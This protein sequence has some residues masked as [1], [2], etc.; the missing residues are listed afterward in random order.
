MTNSLVKCDLLLAQFACVLFLLLALFPIMG[1]AEIPA[2]EEELKSSMGLGGYTFVYQLPDGTEITF[3][4]LVEL[5]KS[6]DYPGFGTELPDGQ[7]TLTLTLL[8]AAE[9]AARDALEELAVATGEEMPALNLPD[10][11]GTV[12]NYEDFG[13]KPLLISFYFSLCPP[14]IKEIPELNEFARENPQVAVVAITFDSTDEARLFAAK[15]GYDWR[16]IADAQGFIDQVGVSAYPAMALVSA[17]GILIATR[18]GEFTTNPD[19]PKVE[20]GWL[21]AWVDEALLTA[22]R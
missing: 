5:V 2:T 15:H 19:E 4:Q 3:E 10:L 22:T 8:S 13:N 12:Y 9:F 21:K 7:K 6:G 18:I 11:A 16:I 1:V 17:D 14:C 20:S